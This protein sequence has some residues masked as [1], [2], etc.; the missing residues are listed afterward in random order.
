MI[1]YW[2]VLYKEI[3][4]E[5]GSPEVTHLRQVATSE[6]GAS[7]YARRYRYKDPKPRGPR[8]QAVYL[9]DGFPGVYLTARESH[10]SLLLLRGYTGRA[11]ADRL[12]LSS[13]TVE[14]YIDN[15]KTK[16]RVRK[17]AEVIGCLLASDFLKNL[18]YSAENELSINH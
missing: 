5:Q 18:G 2:Q 11:I 10:C 8:D 17:R 3:E 15:V 7:D 6:L 16:F 13:R 4:A 9:G 1:D 12:G 14:Y